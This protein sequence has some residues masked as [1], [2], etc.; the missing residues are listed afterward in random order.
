MFFPDKAWKRLVG[1]LFLS[2]LSFSRPIPIHICGTNIIFFIFLFFLF[3]SSYF[4]RHRN[5]KLWRY[6]YR[7]EQCPI[8]LLI[9]TIPQ[10]LFVNCTNFLLFRM[11]QLIFQSWLAIFVFSMYFPVFLPFVDTKGENFTANLL[12]RI[13]SR[14]IELRLIDSRTANLFGVNSRRSLFCNRLKAIERGYKV[15]NAI[16]H[17]RMRALFSIS[18][19]EIVNVT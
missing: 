15:P 6:Y 1:C 12:S 10:I 9:V 16:V 2:R 14:W 7:R 18:I 8:Y 3:L 13:V 5:L 11:L 19:V 17:D 4:S